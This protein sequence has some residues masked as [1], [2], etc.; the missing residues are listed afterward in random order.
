MSQILHQRSCTT[1]SNHQKIRTNILLGALPFD[2]RKVLIILSILSV[3]SLKYDLVLQKDYFLIENLHPMLGNLI[4]LV[5]LL[6]LDQHLL[7]LLFNDPQVNLQVID[8]HPVLLDVI[9]QLK[10]HVLLLDQLHLH[11]LNLVKL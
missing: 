4:V 1:L 10:N 2:L 7:M 3:L 6:I 11:L 9:A 5:N 8:F